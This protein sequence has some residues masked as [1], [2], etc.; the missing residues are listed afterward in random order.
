MS[1]SSDCGPSQY[2]NRST[3]QAGAVGALAG[4]VG[5]VGIGGFFA[6]TSDEGYNRAMKDLTAMRTNLDNA[7]KEQES[8]LLVTQKEYAKRQ[9]ELMQLATT[10]YDTILSQQINTYSVLL[11][12]TFIVMI[13]ILIFLLV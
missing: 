9:V 5:M 1:S 6:P 7:I 10:H 4:F 2:I 8:Q 12:V 11:A 3:T 13:M